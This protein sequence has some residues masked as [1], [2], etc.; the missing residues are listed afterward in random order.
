MADD[1]QMSS[2]PTEPPTPPPSESPTWW[3]PP[4]SAPPT[5][6]PPTSAPPPWSESVGPAA[7]TEPPRRRRVSLWLI[8]LLVL[9][10]GALAG[11]A[12][13]SS[14]ATQQRR[15]ALVAVAT[16]TSRLDRQRRDTRV[17]ASSL[18]ETAAL[19][20]AQISSTTA[21]MSMLQQ[22]SDGAHQLATHEGALIHD[23]EAGAGAD[24]WNADASQANHDIDGI[25]ALFD[26]LDKLAPRFVA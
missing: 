19:G 4:T 26:R 8:L 11:A 3:A 16:A 25:K 21:P 2:Y 20:R 1:D 22:I 10:A 14:H 23:G 17:A 12:A 5:S 18:R 7:P 6:A 15:T 9:C 13:Y 24:V